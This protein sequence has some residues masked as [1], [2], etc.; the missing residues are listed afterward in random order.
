LPRRAKRSET[1]DTKTIG[2][3]LRDL[4]NR[5]GITQAQL[6]EKVGLTQTLV[7]DY[8]I[9]RLRMHAG[10]VVVFAQA[11][12]VT[13]DQILG[14]EAIKPEGLIRNRRLL[15]RLQRIDELPAVDQRALVRYI[16]ALL[17]REEAGRGAKQ[18]TA[19]GHPKRTKGFKVA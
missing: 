15:R 9:G 19:P 4:R 2:K 8:E 13:S 12:H 14:L 5:V 17:S 11:L 1:V 18:A 3:R 7:S 6:G 16:D 10:L